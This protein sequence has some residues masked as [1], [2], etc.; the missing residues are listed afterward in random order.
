M[1]KAPS[2]VEYDQKM[3]ELYLH[4]GNV[5]VSFQHLELMVAA[6]L[7][8]LLKVSWD[9]G[10]SLTSEMSFSRLVAALKCVSHT[11]LKPSPI[12]N[13]LDSFC[14]QL[15]RCEELRN[16]V[17]HAHY[18]Y[19]EGKFV[20]SKITAKQ[21]KGLQKNMDFINSD[22]FADTI[23]AIENSVDQLMSIVR[24]LKNHRVISDSF[25]TG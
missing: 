15:S 23:G 5:V 21:R 17:V 8:E 20:K 11:G 19:H 16:S 25:F 13:R 9:K 4:V 3:Q 7:I 22:A 18:S 6:L 24:D 10:L 12:L 14:V 2:R 1:N